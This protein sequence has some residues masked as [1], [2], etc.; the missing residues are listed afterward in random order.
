[1]AGKP[2]VGDV[3]LEQR[4]T[5]RKRHAIDVG[6]IPGTHDVAPRIRFFPQRLDDLADLV[7]LAA[8]GRAPV[9]PLVAVDRSELARGV[10]PFVPNAHAAL[11]QPPHIGV[12]AQEPQELVDDGLEMQLLRREKREGGLE[13]EAQLPAEHRERAGPGAVALARAA[14][15]HL[16]EK[17]EIL[18]LFGVHGSIR[19]E[20]AAAWKRSCGFLASRPSSQAWCSARCAGSRGTGAFTCMLTTLAGLEESYR[21]SP[22]SIS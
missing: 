5:R 20:T 9:A 4:V 7:D 1:L 2:A 11:L 17:V 10:G 22:V 8:F 18:L 3:E 12:A 19:R 16:G 15:E 13:R 21:R 6:R 14:L